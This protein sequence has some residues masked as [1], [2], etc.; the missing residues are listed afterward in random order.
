MG[1]PPDMIDAD[2]HLHLLGVDS[3]SLMGLFDVARQRF[4][5]GIDALAFAGSPTLGDV[6]AA[7]AAAPGTGHRPPVFV[8][9]SFGPEP[10]LSALESLLARSAGAPPLRMVPP[11]L[12]AMPDSPVGAALVA[13]VRMSDQGAAAIDLERLLRPF[14][15]AVVLL[16]PGTEPAADRAALARALE[17]DGVTVLDCGPLLNG[18]RTRP[19]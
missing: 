3:L 6:A 9:S 16:C 13:A 5:N 15:R 18:R 11:G 10:L 7:L 17:R 8:A 4:G 2:M 19:R 1:V 14:D 12:A